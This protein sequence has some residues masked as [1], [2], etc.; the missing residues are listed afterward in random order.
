MSGVRVVAC[1]KL[2]LSFEVLGKRSDGFHEVRTVM[3]S[4]S[5]CDDLL[6]EP[7]DILSL[8]C[9]QTAPRGE[10]NL[11]MRA[12]QELRSLET[13]A[14]AEARTQHP[15]PSTQHSA[16]SPEHPEPRT[17]PPR[18]GA[19]ILL[20]KGIPTAAGLGGASADAAAALVGLARLW[21]LQPE[22]LEMASLAAR[23]GSDVPFFLTGGTA[24]ALGRGE[25][26]QPLPDAPPA[27]VAL[28]TTEHSL[29]AKT[30]QMYRLLGPEQWSSGSTTDRLAD[31]I[32]LHRGLDPTLLCNAFEAVADRVFPDLSHRRQAMLDAGAASVHLTGSGPTLFSLFDNEDGARRLAQRLEKTGLR[33]LVART[34]TA[35]EARPMP[36]Q[37]Q[38]R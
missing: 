5:L 22:P 26:V 38:K 31:S 14:P 23:L 3:Q 37:L 20:R 32:R 34:L 4:I 7:A 6:L 17:T 35:S 28:V 36:T 15:A 21:G 27:W 11:V 18:P 33:S 2:N 19:G 1:A 12:A 10:A 16:R 24:L 29:A 8:E 25:M 13:P 30:A 9:D